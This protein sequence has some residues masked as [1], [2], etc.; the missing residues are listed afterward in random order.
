MNEESSKLTPISIDPLGQ[1]DTSRKI[2]VP[3][4]GTDCDEKCD[5]VEGEPCL[6][7]SVSAVREIWVVAV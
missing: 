3:L 4:C 6:T 1:H 5:R 7:R 2:Y